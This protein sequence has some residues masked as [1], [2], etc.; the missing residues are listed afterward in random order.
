M[1]WWFNPSRP[2]NL[3]Y[4]GALWDAYKLWHPG[5]WSACRQAYVCC[6][7]T[8]AAMAEAGLRGEV[9]TYILAAALLQQPRGHPTAHAAATCLL[10]LVY[11]PG[12]P[13]SAPLGCSGPCFVQVDAPTPRRRP[14]GRRP[15]TGPHAGPTHRGADAQPVRPHVRPEHDAGQQRHGSQHAQVHV[16]RAAAHM[17]SS[18]KGQ[19]T[20]CR[21]VSGKPPSLTPSAPCAGLLQA[22]LLCRWPAGNGAGTRLGGLARRAAAQQHVRPGRSHAPRA[23]AERRVDR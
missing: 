8:T 17:T 9:A 1:A 12:V 4:E 3:T 19:S 20:P 16:S 14:K 23:L 11:G 21:A 22:P 2:S 5:A 15:V 10:M 18:S 6:C 7:V 13:P